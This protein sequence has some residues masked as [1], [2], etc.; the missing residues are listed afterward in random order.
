[1]AL[2]SMLRGLKR[3]RTY[4]LKQRAFCAFVKGWDT[5]KRVVFLPPQFLTTDQQCHLVRK[6][7]DAQK[8]IGWNLFLWEYLHMKW[9]RAQAAFRSRS[10]EDSN[11]DVHWATGKSMMIFVQE[12]WVGRCRGI[13]VTKK[14]KESLTKE[15]RL[16]EIRKL[17][18]LPRK[19]ISNLEK[20]LH[21]KVKRHVKYAPEPTVIRWLHLL[22]NARAGAIQRRRKTEQ[23]QKGMKSLAKKYFNILK[24]GN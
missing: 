4:P 21:T 24:R 13:H 8:R 1:M 14:G 19:M 18:E 12:S 3:Y 17:V 23:V 11:R 6:A 15:E 5:K 10:D 22:R 7:S 2:G 9:S 16:V 20:E